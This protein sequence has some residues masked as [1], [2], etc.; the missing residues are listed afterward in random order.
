MMVLGRW[1]VAVFDQA[2][3]VLVLVLVPFGSQ[4]LEGLLSHAFDCFVLLEDVGAA[5]S[6]PGVVQIQ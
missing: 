2:L 1:L 4:L 3:D 5:S 6:Q